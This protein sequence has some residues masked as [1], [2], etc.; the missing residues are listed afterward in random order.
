MRTIV[1][2]IKKAGLKGRGGG[3]F[4]TALKWQIVKKAKA[5]K[6]YVVCN[7]SEGEPGVKK[8]GYI[9]ENYIDRVIDGMQIAMDYLSATEGYLYVN[10]HYFHNWRNK[11]LRAIGPARIKLFPKS[12]SAGYI[13]GEETAALNHLSGQR[14]EPRLRPPYPTIAGLGSFPTLINNVETFYDVSL[15]A[16]GEY[17][18]ERF[19]TING[20]VIFT[21]IFS[22]PEDWSINKI[23]AK[24][25]NTPHFDFFAQIGGD[26]SG[27]VLSSDQLERPVS[28]SGSI[29]V[30]SLI[31][32]KPIDLIKKWV[33][34]FANES[35]GKCTP[36]REGTYRLREILRHKETD[37]QMFAD[38]L[39][40]LSETSF[41]GLGSAASVAISSYVKNVLSQ[42]PD[43]KIPAKNFNKKE[44]CECF[45]RNYK[46]IVNS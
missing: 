5:D 23:L 21:G 12:H 6:K 22:F 11:L 34:F 45:K 30:Y 35:C 42:T 31:K 27:E 10:P 20:D 36:C 37:W 2:K 8:D 3:A 32:H 39:T 14:V 4:D 15:I 16:A 13:G 1:Q 46:L 19:I 18:N 43:N 41:C 25:N 9:L 44:L 38:I 26:A 33:N 29:T 7:A 17:K 24:S 28:G 40:N